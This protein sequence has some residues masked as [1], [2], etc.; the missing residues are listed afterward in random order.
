MIAGLWLWKAPVPRDKVFDD[1]GNRAHRSMS[2]A[3]AKRSR[4]NKHL[5]KVSHRLLRVLLLGFLDGCNFNNIRLD[6][7]RRAI[8]V[9][10]A[11]QEMLGQQWPRRRDS[12]IR[13]SL[14]RY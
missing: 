10:G 7:F 12:A 14:E 4:R 9:R 6:Y 2:M 8:P 11:T 1:R 13:T 5:Q 3:T